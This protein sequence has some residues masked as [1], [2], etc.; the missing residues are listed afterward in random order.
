MYMSLTYAIAK[1]QIFFG[2][3]LTRTVGTTA[4]SALRR[5]TAA[6]TATCKW[7]HHVAGTSVLACKTT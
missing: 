2:V 1:V 3:A 4:G 5:T 7:H 6:A